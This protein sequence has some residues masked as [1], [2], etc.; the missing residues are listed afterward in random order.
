M[1]TFTIIMLAI[2]IARVLV[3]QSKEKDQSAYKWNAT[4]IVVVSYA[5]C[6][7]WLISVE[8]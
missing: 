6:I 5:L 8:A 1:K 3:Q 2:N 4:I 7:N